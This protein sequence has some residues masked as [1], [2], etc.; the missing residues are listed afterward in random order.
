MSKAVSKEVAEK[1]IDGYFKKEYP[2][3]ESAQPTFWDAVKELVVNINADVSGLINEEEAFCVLD[4]KYSSSHISRYGEGIRTVTDFA[5]KIAQQIIESES[6][7]VSPSE[8]FLMKRRI[9]S[10]EE[11]M[12]YAEMRYKKYR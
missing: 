12:G 8:V 7:P 6:K 2:I 5:K 10:L 1:Y 3:L 11:R 9:E 4:G